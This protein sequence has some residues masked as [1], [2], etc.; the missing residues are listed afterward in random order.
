[1]SLI[2]NRARAYVNHG[3]WVADC[4]IGC[5][6]ALELQPGQMLFPCPECKTIS[7]T[8]WPENADEIW[9]ALQKRIMPRTRNWYP[10]GHEVALRGG[11]AHGQTV[12]ELEDEAAEF[13]GR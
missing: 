11:I 8:D 6:C 7:E 9:D 4:P 12:K 3:R 10:S 13:T 2:T 5:G 1:M